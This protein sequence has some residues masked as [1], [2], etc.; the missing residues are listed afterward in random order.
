MMLVICRWDCGFVS[1]NL[2]KISR[3]WTVLKRAGI[4]TFVAGRSK[5]IARRHSLTKCSGVRNTA[6]RVL[7][8]EASGLVSIRHHIS[9][10]QEG[11]QCSGLVMGY[12]LVV[13]IGSFNKMCT[14]TSVC[15]CEVQ[16]RGTKTTRHTD[17][18]MQILRKFP[19]SSLLMETEF[20]PV[21]SNM[22]R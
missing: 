19:P 5:Y 11:G 20:E 9:G 7:E 16:Q 4:V 15:I 1:G 6:T 8:R 3:S 22:T 21:F 12:T 14:P 13:R 2:L 10:I 17:D 18:S